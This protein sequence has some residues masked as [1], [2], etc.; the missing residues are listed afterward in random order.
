MTWSCLTVGA[1]PRPTRTK[2]GHEV[3]GS[4]SKGDNVAP[5]GQVIEQH[6]L[7]WL[8]EYEAENSH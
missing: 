8:I 2:H 5:D 7:R 3:T 1:S 6:G 4:P